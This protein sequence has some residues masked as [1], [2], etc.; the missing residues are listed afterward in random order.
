MKHGKG[1]GK[2]VMLLRYLSSGSHDKIPQMRWLKATEIYFLIVLEKSK[3]L[4][5][6]VSDLERASPFLC[7]CK[8]SYQGRA[9]W[10]LFLQGH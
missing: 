4:A 10:C 1:M 7:A 5:I 8:G 6:L 3:V 2:Q 9:I